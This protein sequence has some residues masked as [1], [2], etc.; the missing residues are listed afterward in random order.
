MRIQPE[1][2]DWRGFWQNNACTD[3]STRKI[4]AM[5]G[6]VAIKVQGSDDKALGVLAINPQFCGKLGMPITPA[7]ATFR[8]TEEPAAPAPQPN[9]SD[10]GTN[11]KSEH[12]TNRLYQIFY[13][14][15]DMCQRYSPA[16][17]VEVKAEARI[18]MEAHPEL[19]KALYESPYFASSKR[20]MDKD[21]ED[22]AE[23]ANSSCQGDLSMLKKMNSP[24]F[25]EERDQAVN[26][27]I[28]DLKG[29]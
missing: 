17:A 4:L 19:I 25:E 28:T 20:K 1:L 11:S 5:G 13:G 23:F 9:A 18:F 24:E 15:V 3:P 22:E 8:S 6:A 7:D 21:I 27:W 26:Q 10:W 2:K 16:L 29:Q 14:D 12:T